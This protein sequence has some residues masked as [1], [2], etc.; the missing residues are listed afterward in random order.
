MAITLTG[1]QQRF[2]EPELR[3]D[4]ETRRMSGTVM[5]YNET[6]VIDK[7]RNIKERF[8]PGAFGDLTRADVI[9]NYQ[10][11]RRDPLARTDGGDLMMRD[12]ATDLRMEAT[13]P[14]T[15][16]ADDA[17]E[18][19]RTKVLRG[20]SVEFMPDKYRIE[21][22][23]TIVHER[24]E[25][26]NFGLV[27]RP[28]YKG[29]EV[30]LRGEDDVTKEEIKAMVAGELEAHRAEKSPLTLEAVVKIVTDQVTAGFK[31][32]DDDAKKRAETDTAEKLAEAEAEHRGELL[33]NMRVA[34][35]L[36]K[37]FDAAGKTVKDILVASVGTEVTDASK[38][39]EGYLERALEEITARRSTAKGGNTRPAPK[40][41]GDNVPLRAPM[42]VTQMRNARKGA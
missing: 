24:A 4:M 15:R 10:H 22:G 19:V 42:S 9:F 26:T 17:I 7:K 32:R 27:D 31:T 18:L 36:P 41:V 40:S 5:P 29:A 39:S 21:G 6:A 8:E 38:R 34:G 1:T 25:L 33:A 30:S 35:L 3:F 14:K 12:S 23:D 20:L 37:G 16:I 2:F 13:L 28:A 11:Q